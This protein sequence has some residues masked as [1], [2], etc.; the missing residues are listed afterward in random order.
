[1][2]L[3]DPTWIRDTVDYSFGDE[4]G[5]GIGGYM[6]TANSSN[7]EFIQR[8]HQ[9]VAAK[10]PYMTL[11]ID[12]MRLYQRSCYRYTAVEKHNQSWKTIRDGKVR[13]FSNEDL[14]RLCGS[15]PDMKFVIFTGFEDMP[16]D[17]GIYETIP[18]NVI[19][20]YACNCM[21][22]GGKV[23]PFPYGLQR[24]TAPN[25]A[26]QDVILEQVNVHIQP[27]KLMYI[28]F[29]IGNHPVRGPLANHY[30]QYPWVT[31][32]NPGLGLVYKEAA[33]KYYNN[34]RNHKFMLCPSGNA[35]GSECHRDWETLYMRRVPIVQDTAYLREIFKGIPVLFVENLMNITEQLLIDNDYLY[36]Q[37][38]IY[39][40][41]K[42]D[43]EV[44]YNNILNKINS[45][46]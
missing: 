44:M 24:K 21:V 23:H 43:I 29:N 40:L 39:D 13:Q 11:F 45:Q 20:V 12:N 3:L 28:N 9:A 33:L 14:L 42:I 27:Q 31:V 5:I 2:R 36:Q 30:A 15:L 4:S 25:D 35:D 10:K 1:M 41:S 17:E 46:L 32:H 18:K 7:G 8:Y 6:R 16:I 26:R 22:W 19:A 34:I 37:M 38:Q